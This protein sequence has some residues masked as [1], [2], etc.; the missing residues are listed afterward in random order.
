M[1]YLN[2][3][4]IL[5]LRSVKLLLFY[6]P[7]SPFFLMLLFVKNKHRTKAS[8][9]D[10]F[11]SLTIGEI[12]LFGKQRI[13]FRKVYEKQRRLFV[14][15]FTSL[16]L[17]FFLPG[18]WFT[19]SPLESALTILHSPIE[20]TTFQ[21]IILIPYIYYLILFDESRHKIKANHGIGCA[22]AL[23]VIFQN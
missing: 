2:I 23:S 1:K 18:Q 12:W 3:I 11:M 5:A 21:K 17:L 7:M 14:R 13:D 6:I 16:N 20:K 9:F 19:L 10:K 15:E 22:L 8:L 4:V